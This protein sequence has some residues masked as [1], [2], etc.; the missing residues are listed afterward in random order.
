MSESLASMIAETN[1]GRIDLQDEVRRVRDWHEHRAEQTWKKA[2]QRWK[3]LKAQQRF[4]K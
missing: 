1:K 4:W 3:K 2:R